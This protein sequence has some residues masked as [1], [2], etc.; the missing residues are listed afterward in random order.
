MAN[1]KPGM[2]T[3]GTGMAK[4]KSVRPRAEKRHKAN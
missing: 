1:A 2:A 3:A 4:A